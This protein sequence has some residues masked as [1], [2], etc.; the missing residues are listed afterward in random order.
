VVGPSRPSELGGRRLTG[1]VELPS[2]IGALAG[3][4][5][6]RADRLL[7]ATAV[8]GRTDPPISLEPWLRE[9]FGS[10]DAVRR[11]SMLRVT[12]LA[13]LDATLFAPLR[14]RRPLDG[15][16]RA[17]DLA[18]EIAGT[19]GDPFCDPEHATPADTF[20]RVR[21]ARMVSGANAGLADAHHAVLVFDDH[22]PLAFDAKLVA[23]LF[24]TGR[25]WADRARA[26]DPDSDAYFL[27]WNCLWKAGGSIVHG[28]AQAMVGAE[29]HARVERFRRDADV[30]RGRCGADLTSDLVAVH[31]EL[32]LTVDHD[33]ATILSHLV[34]VKERELLVVAP[35]GTDERD[36]SFTAAVARALLAYRDRLGVRSFNLALWRPPLTTDGRPPAGWE[37]FPTMVRIVDRGDP[38]SRPSDIG[39]MELYGTPIVG[40]DPYD[41]L[42]ALAAPEPRRLA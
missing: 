28:H 11:Q 5:R 31:R 2:R 29:H 7:R 10:V 40:A 42:A 9:T 38:F 21:G 12:N 1:I 15:P 27:L 25:A 35:A 36:P 22:D 37:E 19:E 13:T 23:D 30:Y 20:G 14:S 8:T 3:D 18:E 41:V 33:G 6:P 16:A 24:A 34:P 26:E 17:G 32:G 39:A 4:A